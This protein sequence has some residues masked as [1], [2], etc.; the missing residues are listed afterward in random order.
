MKKV[1]QLKISTFTVGLIFKFTFRY[2]IDIKVPNDSNDKNT[3]KKQLRIV[4]NNFFSSHEIM[5]FFINIFF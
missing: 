4:H 3:K 2:Q 1:V 5:G